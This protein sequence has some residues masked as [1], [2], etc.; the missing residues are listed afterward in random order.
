MYCPNCGNKINNN[1]IYCSNCGNKITKDTDNKNINIIIP[2]L[3]CVF[4]WIPIISIPLA[5]I[6]IIIGFTNNNKKPSLIIL[7]ILSILLSILEIVIIIIFTRY[8]INGINYDK[9]EDKYLDKF[10]EYYKRIEEYTTNEIKGYSWTTNNNLT[11][12]LYNNN[13]YSIYDNSEK[14]KGKYEL[15]NG[16]SAIEYIENNL[17]ENSI[18]EDIQKNIIKDKGYTIKDYYLIIFT[19]DNEIITYYYGFYNN[20]YLELTNIKNNDKLILNKKEKISDIDI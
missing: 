3:A 6:S 16:E 13:K 1:E 18:S 20:E 14:E 9:I 2:I 11:I 8:L 5:I 15:Y 10:N 7:G 4:F 19:N 12:Y 17:E